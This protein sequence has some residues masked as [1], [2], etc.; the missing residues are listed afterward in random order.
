[1]RFIVLLLL[2]MGAL[3]AWRH[4]KSWSYG[5][6]GFM[7]LLMVVLLIVLSLGCL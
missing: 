7:G 6:S 1:M 5:P 4:G 3:P 2:L